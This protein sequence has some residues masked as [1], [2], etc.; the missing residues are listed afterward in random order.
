[1]DT[2]LAWEGGFVDYEV[3][4]GGGVEGSVVWGRACDLFGLFHFTLSVCGWPR[5]AG[6]SFSPHKCSLMKLPILYPFPGMLPAIFH[7]SAQSSV[8]C[9]LFTNKLTSPFYGCTTHASSI[10]LVIFIELTTL[11]I[12]IPISP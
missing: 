5:A 4:E 3:K 9:I 8:H 7:D 11:L 2:P 12:G 10:F 1:M 6:P